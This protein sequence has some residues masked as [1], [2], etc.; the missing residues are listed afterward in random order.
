MQRR[1]ARQRRRSS[2]WWTSRT[3]AQ[4]RCQP[5]RCVATGHTNACQGYSHYSCWFHGALQSTCHPPVLAALGAD[6]EQQEY[7]ELQVTNVVRLLG[8]SSD[9]GVTPTE[10]LAAI[11]LSKL[12]LEP[13]AHAHI[14]R[15]SAIPVGALA[16]DEFC[17]CRPWSALPS[18]R[19]V[20]CNAALHV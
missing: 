20:L 16:C 11:L 2:S 19:R 17:L 8:P 12:A 3:P 13:E 7:P 14:A 6:A 4:T 5:A 1:W 18:R 15:A 9:E 10:E